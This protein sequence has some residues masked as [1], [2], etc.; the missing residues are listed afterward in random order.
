MN[1]IPA[2]GTDNCASSPPVAG[3]GRRSGAGVMLAL[4]T[5]LWGDA[6]TQ[7]GT[8]DAARDL[9]YR[10]EY[11]VRPDFEAGGAFVELH[12]RQPRRLLRAFDM[13][14]PSEVFSDFGGDGDVSAANDRLLWTPPDGGGALRWFARIDHKRNGESYDAYISE[15]WAIFRAEDIMPPAATRSLKGARSET[16]LRFVL[17]SGWSSATEYFG[18][19]HVYR[20]ENPERAFDRPAGWMI[21]GRIGTRVETIA[22][23]RTK[24]AAPIG[25]GVRRMDILAML[26][27]TM[28]DV[29]R[30]LPDFPGRLTI[31][32]AG[33]PMWR[34]GLSGPRSMF[35][36]AERPLISE[37]AT[38][39][40]LHEIMHIG[41]ARGAGANVD[42]VVEGL[43][44]YYGL[45]ILR[46][47]GTIS[48][49]RFRAALNRLEQW[50]NEAHSLCRSNASGAVTAKA[51]TV[52]R[53]LD[54]EISAHSAGSE[55]LDDVIR[56]LAADEEITMSG[57]R[58]AVVELLG[59]DADAL[60]NLAGC[61][62]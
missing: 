25:H 9:I 23:V 53:D 57:F 14:A 43:A 3:F 17:P 12:L 54:R 51:V 42:W 33:D 13:R 60:N 41:L 15:D 52:M 32:S 55:S 29:L 26:H 35:L 47:S 46:R 48:E 30:L 61:G 39:T 1:C 58:S 7:D 49:R 59:E 50:G 62:D 31:I 40:L 36:H 2:S 8:P 38:S 19:D 16:S 34:G 22:G 18:R 4:A 27:W 6:H 45:E 28:P 5:L 24:I 10:L 21:V 56:A 20:T 37:N 11:I 44:E